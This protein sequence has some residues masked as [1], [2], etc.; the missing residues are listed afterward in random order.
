MAVLEPIK[1]TERQHG[2]TGR[3][4]LV[5]VRIAACSQDG[6]ST[7]QQIVILLILADDEIA[8]LVIAPVAVN[9]MH[10]RPERQRPP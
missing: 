2:L 4:N 1:V 5:G 3:A 9:V 7:V 10:L 6:R 8:S